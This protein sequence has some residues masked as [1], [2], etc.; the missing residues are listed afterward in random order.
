MKKVFRAPGLVVF[1]LLGLVIGV[2]WWLYADTLVQRGVEA[3]G[4]SLVGAKVDLQSVDLHPSD[5]SFNR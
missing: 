5:G 2:A 3:T 4:E 1:G